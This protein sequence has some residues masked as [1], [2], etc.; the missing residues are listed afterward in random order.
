MEILN[1]E[2]KNLKT[3]IEEGTIISNKGG[4]CT[5]FSSGGRVI[6][7]QKELYQYLKLNSIRFADSVVCDRY[8]NRNQPW[9]RV[10]FVDVEQ[11]RYFLEQQKNIQLTTFDKGVVTVNADGTPVV[12]GVILNDLTDYKDITGIELDSPSILLKLLYNLLHVSL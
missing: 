4:S 2:P 1:L 6:K 12:C 10:P 11:V 3:M 9:K 5:V 7:L 8:G